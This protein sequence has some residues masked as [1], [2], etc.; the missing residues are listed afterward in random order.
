MM[1]QNLED[2]RRLVLGA[3]GHGGNGQKKGK[4]WQ[5]QRKK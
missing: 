1:H 4:E 2:M 5:G 3:K